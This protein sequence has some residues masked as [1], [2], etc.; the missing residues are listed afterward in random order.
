MSYTFQDNIQQIFCDKKDGNIFHPAQFLETIMSNPHLGLCMLKANRFTPTAS[1]TL[2]R[3]V[4]PK[5][6][7]LKCLFR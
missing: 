7:S 2:T 6:R 4:L 3:A 5:L 1:I